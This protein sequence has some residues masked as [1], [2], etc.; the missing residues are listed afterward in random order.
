LTIAAFGWAV[1]LFALVSHYLPDGVAAKAVGALVLWTGLHPFFRSMGYPEKPLWIATAV[2]APA[3][4]LAHLS[5]P[6][7]PEAVQTWFAPVLLG[8]AAVVSV[9]RVMTRRTRPL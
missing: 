4:M 7:V 9:L 6:V 3:V 5:K 8:I 2:F 1:L